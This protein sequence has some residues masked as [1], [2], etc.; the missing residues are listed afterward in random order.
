MKLQVLHQLSY[1]ALMVEV[2]QWVL[3]WV[4]ESKWV[5]G[6]EIGS[7]WALFLVMMGDSTLAG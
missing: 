4:L 1:L 3:L 6:W 5:Q 7:G 2:L